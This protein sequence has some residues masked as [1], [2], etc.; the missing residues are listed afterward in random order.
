MAPIETKQDAVWDA[1]RVGRIG[2]QRE[3]ADLC[4]VRSVTHRPGVVHDFQPLGSP[5][6]PPPWV[7]AD[8]DEHLYIPLPRAT[9]VIHHRR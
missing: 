3:Q 4:R 2:G 9:S 5:A 8:S 1:G 7:S 6:G